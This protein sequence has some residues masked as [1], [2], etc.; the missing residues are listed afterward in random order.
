MN[1]KKQLPRLKTRTGKE[2]QPKTE[3]KNLNKTS[4]L[5]RGQNTWNTPMKASP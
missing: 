3:R 5:E 4:I 1:N 2:E